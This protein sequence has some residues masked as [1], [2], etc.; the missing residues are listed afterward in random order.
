MG[1]V[2]S[3]NVTKRNEFYAIFHHIYNIS[4][5]EKEGNGYMTDIGKSIKY[6]REC[7]HMTQGE[8]AEKLGVY[9]QAVSKW[10]NGSKDGDCYPQ[11][12]R[13]YDIV[14]VLECDIMELFYDNSDDFTDIIVID[15]TERYLE[16]LDTLVK[17]HS[18]DKLFCFCMKRAAKQH[19][20][21][22]DGILYKTLYLSKYEKYLYDIQLKRKLKYMTGVPDIDDIND[23]NISFWIDNMNSDYWCTVM[24]KIRFEGLGYEIHF[25]IGEIHYYTDFMPEYQRDM[26]RRKVP[27]REMFDKM[28]EYNKTHKI[29]L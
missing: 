6:L 16:A 9:Q 1:R 13:L 15:Y 2:F 17:E 26:I 5:Q 8:L 27:E 20:D 21:D 11:L 28:C 7:K 22:N 18:S 14:N 12:D 29:P 25:K 23:F 3:K 24:N 4:I 10:E 19:L